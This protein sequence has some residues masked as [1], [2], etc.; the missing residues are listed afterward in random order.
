MILLCMGRDEDGDAAGLS[1]ITGVTRDEGSHD[2]TGGLETH[3]K[4]RDVQQKDV[5]VTSG[6]SSENVGLDCGTVCNGL[7]RVDGATWLLAVEV[8][9][10]Q[11]PGP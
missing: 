2:A 6:A 9:G 10:D 3:G 5:G 7:V 11:P 4:R 1:R 8:V